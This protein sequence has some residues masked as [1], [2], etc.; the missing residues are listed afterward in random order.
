MKPQKHQQHLGLS[1]L[2][3]SFPRFGKY[4]HGP[5][6]SQEEIMQFVAREGSAVIESPTGTGKTAVEY[7]ILKAAQKKMKGPFF[8]VTPNKTLVEQIKKEFPDLKVALGRNEHECFYYWPDRFQADE[9][10]CSMLKYCPYR[11]N[12]ETGETFQQG[13]EACPYLL[14]KY[15]AK[16]GGI[17]LCTMSFYLFC[18]LFTK[19]FDTPGALVID[20]AHR[21]ADV[22]RNSLSYEI[23]DYHLKQS[24]K[25]LEKIE[26]EEVKTLKQLLNYMKRVCKR[27]P[28]GEETLLEDKEVRHLI[29]ILV[30]ID[31][32]LLIQKIEQAVEEGAID[33]VQDRIT[34]RRLEVLVRDLNRYLRSFEYSLE[35]DE[36]K[37]LNYTCA[38]YRLEKDEH[39][40]IQ[41]KLIIKC[42]SVAPLIRKILSPFT[43]SLSATIGDPEKFAW[44]TGIDQ[45]FLALSST[46]PVDHARV[47]LP[48]D[49]PNLA[50]KARRKRDV[51]RALRKI[52][53]A[54]KRLADQGYRSL[55][56]TISNK[57]R[58]KFLI[59]AAEEGVE[60]LS[61]GNGRTAKEVALA[62]REGEGDVLVGTAANYSEGV[63]LPKQIAPVIFFLRPGYPRPQDPGTIF[64]ERRWGSSRSWALRNWRVMQQALQVRGR[65]IRGRND[66]GVTFFISQQFK[67]VLFPALPSWLEKAYRSKFTFEEALADAEKL[68]AENVG[69]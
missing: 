57:E 21:I 20:E 68:L 64:E 46:F 53:R 48:K 17:V 55:V 38:F 25:L 39:Q 27:K 14:Q 30:T 13:A 18:Q 6:K 26:A 3:A 1:E 66:I 54:C 60:A 45:P 51:T 67:R 16:Q 5:W 61:Y 9:V 44:E 50:V 63:D 37:P 42:Y 62:F 43:V 69:L 35:T 40:K 8:L 23:S 12:Q 49:T 28:V 19:E 41:Y 58:Q 32:N 34:L 56:V 7:A 59:L 24:I 29:K 65:N 36:R 47:Y 4:R 31:A 22:V 11:V 15:E 52:A 33:P 10:P 2:Q